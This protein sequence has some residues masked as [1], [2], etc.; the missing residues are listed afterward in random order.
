MALDDSIIIHDVDEN[1]IME[2]QILDCKIKLI[3]NFDVYIKPKIII[4]KSVE[5]LLL[6]SLNEHR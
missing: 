2:F 4:A 6:L 3:N 1:Y 5:V